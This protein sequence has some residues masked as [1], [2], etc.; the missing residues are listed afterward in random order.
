MTRRFL[1]DAF[2]LSVLAAY[3]V[4]G[5]ALVPFHGD[6]STLVYMSRD[7]GYQVLQG[8]W[9][10]VRFDDAWAHPDEQ[11]LRMINGSIA[12]YTFGFAWHLAGYSLAEVN[13]FW[14]WRRD[15]NWNV[16]SGRLPPP[17]ML[18]AARIASS[19][20]LAASIVA[21]FVLARHVGGRPVAYLS[22]LY[23][24]LNP[25]VL[26][27]G[28]RAMM[29]GAFL[30]FGV[31]VV[32]A[33]ISYVRRP[34]WSSAMVLG[35]VGGLALAAKHTNLFPMA[36]IF[37]ACAVFPFF[38]R[39]RPMDA[40]R[41]A[42]Y[43]VGA[44]VAATAAFLA[45]NPVWWGMNP[46]SLATAILRDRRN[47][48]TSYATVYGGYPGWL[49]QFT[50]FF[51]QAFVV[52]PQYFEVSRF[53]P[54]IADQ[55][56][57]YDASPLSGVSLGGSLL[58]GLI[59]LGLV[60]VGIITFLRSKEIAFP[61]RYLVGTWAVTIVLSTVLLTPLEWQRY[62]LPIFPIVAICSALGLVRLVGW[63]VAVLSGR[64]LRAS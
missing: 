1:R 56:V 30:L 46:V 44:V 17:G 29:E 52:T 37:S 20:Y 43:L 57:A 45:L 54:W 59:M 24:A 19:L 18:L 22:C 34:R 16:S 61:V 49:D 4:A 35:A 31:L 38:D 12:K 14:D 60:G 64:L 62:Y 21:L 10:R 55:I 41:A 53:G 11:L 15:W 58:G 48:L 39:L 51:R 36:A 47:L 5:T 63:G 42:G 3:V 2:F 33:G 8:D 25:A 27:N 40:A 7:Y 9:S 28:R 13:K 23:Y 26:L 50:G 32:L 6:E